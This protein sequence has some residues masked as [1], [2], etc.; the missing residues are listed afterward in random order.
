MGDG[1]RTEDDEEDGHGEEVPGHGGQ[2]SSLV[3]GT[4]KVAN[5]LNVQTKHTT[6]ASWDVGV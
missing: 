4:F 2:R 6:K 5:W 3:V 1:A